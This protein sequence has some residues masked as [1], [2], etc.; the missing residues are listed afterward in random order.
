MA[1]YQAGRRVG[2]THQVL[3]VE[4]D[5]VTIRE[6]T[7]LRLQVLGSAQSVS[8]N[9]TATLAHD[10]SLRRAEFT[11]QSSGSSFRAKA[12]RVPDGLEVELDFAGNRF[13]EQL[14]MPDEVYLP[15]ALRASVR[16]DRLQIGVEVIESVWDPFTGARLQQTLR[17][18]AREAVPERT[19]TVMAWKVVED[20]RGVRTAAWLA[21]DG[22]VWR[23]EGPLGF[24]LVRSSAE[25][26]RAVAAEVEG[27]IDVGRFAAIPT[28]VIESPRTLQRL[29]IRLRGASTWRVSDTE[30]R[31]A[32][33]ELTIARVPPGPT[34][35]YALPA[36]G[37]A[38]SDLAATIFLQSD[39]PRV[40]TLAKEILAGETDAQRAAI[41][42]NDWVYEYLDKVPTVS[43]PNALQVIES[44]RGDCNEHAVLFAGLSRA[45]GLPARVV[46]GLVYIDGAFLYHAWSEVWLGGWVSIDPSLRQFPADATHVKLLEGGP[47]VHGELLEVVGRIAIEVLEV[48]SPK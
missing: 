45:V 28:N 13:E 25:E 24:V 41:R 31:W 38:A 36:R 29:R 11:M 46:A 30:Q 39:H 9:L 18:V 14:P 8:T 40:R 44:A 32:E 26:A 12:D 15:Q 34:Q 27:E 42:L 33:D 16:G 43:V 35:T 7:S 47:E 20:I 37:A 21:D 1:V 17:V 2:F 3:W 6:A 22:S 10:Y 4:A 19:P 48:G 5:T 23:E